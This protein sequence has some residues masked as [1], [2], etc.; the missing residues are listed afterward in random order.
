MAREKSGSMAEAA[1]QKGRTKHDPLTALAVRMKRGD[2]KAA[3][4]LYN[5]LM[6]KAYG[7]FFTRTGKKEIAEDLAQDMF[8]KLV[9]KVSYFDE[10]RGRFVVWFWQ[11]ARNLLIDHYREKKETAF[12]MFEEREVEAMAVT[13]MPDVD[14]RLRYR[15]VQKFLATMSEDERELFELRYVAGLPYRDIADI[16]GRSEGALRVAS[17]RIKEKIQKELKQ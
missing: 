3:G 5:E 6:P 10:T 1:K 12:S 9:E 13:E 11:M 8:V 15:E 2:R 17:L 4:A 14:D 16:L 7:F